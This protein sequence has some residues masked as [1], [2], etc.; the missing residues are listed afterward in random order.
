M[1]IS[2]IHIRKL[3]LFLLATTFFWVSQGVTDSQWI[4]CATLINAYAVKEAIVGILMEDGVSS[5]KEAMA[6]GVW[7]YQSLLLGS[8]AWAGFWLTTVILITIWA[9][10]FSTETKYYVDTHIQ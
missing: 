2:K 8:L 4:L 5:T 10:H 7:V 9:W 3:T 1:K 6:N